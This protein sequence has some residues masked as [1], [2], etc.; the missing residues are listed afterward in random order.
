MTLSEL[1]QRA[2]GTGPISS[3]PVRHPWQT[4]AGVILVIALGALA[5]SVATN[6][7]IRWDIVA[8][9]LT[10]SS[11]LDGLVTTIVLTVVAMVIGL[12]LGV[13][14]AVARLSSNR[15]LQAIAGG[16]IWAF[17]STPLLVQLLLWFNLALFFPRLG[18][19]EFSVDT[20]TI[21]TSFVAAILGLGLNE[22][23]YMAEIVRG[24]I[25]AVDRGQIEAASAL[26][27]RSR[28]IMWRIILP[29]AM[30]VIIPPVGNNVITMLKMTSLVSVI[31]VPDLLNRA[32]AIS[33]K[34]FFLFELLIVATLWYLV[35]TTLLTI[36]Q[37]QLEK[38]FARG[39]SAERPRL[40]KKLARNL[41]PGRV[42][43]TKLL[44]T[45]DEREITEEDRR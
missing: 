29:Q 10:A 3:V 27:M 19:G 23:A 11:I 26:G 28:K 7:S 41:M 12:V 15:V 6:D 2:H 14:L 44:T 22:A 4:L 1:E 25:Q 13:L 24:G 38:R 40:S 32:Q 37:A 18:I 16:Y 31:A 35:L 33:A 20:N 34:N 21:M 5:W 30:R 36:V 9:N 45:I 17:R 8:K 39:F 43:N 42:T